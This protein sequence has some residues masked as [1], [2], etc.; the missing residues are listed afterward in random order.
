[1]ASQYGVDLNSWVEDLPVGSQQRVEILKLLYRGAR[2]LILDE[3]TAVLSPPETDE[4]FRN[5]R[6]LRDQGNTIILIT[7]KL[8][9]ILALT[10]RVTVMRQGRTIADLDTGS[11]TE[12]QLADLWE[13][14]S[15]VRVIRVHP[16]AVP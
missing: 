14:F 3:P 7:H 16:V 4:L 12:Q 15:G 10:D 5:L 11:A 13:V 1:M 8:R 6:I 2:I 9:E